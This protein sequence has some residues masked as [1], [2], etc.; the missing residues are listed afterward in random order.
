LKLTE[1]QIAKVLANEE[2]VNQLWSLVEGLAVEVSTEQFP[3]ELDD[4]ECRL[5]ETMFNIIKEESQ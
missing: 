1:A 3:A 5:A 2:V 4:W